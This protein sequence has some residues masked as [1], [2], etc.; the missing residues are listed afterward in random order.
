M[1]KLLLTYFYRLP[2]KYSEKLTIQ[3]I[4]LMLFA[5][6]LG[7]MVNY[8]A[9]SN[10][11]MFSNT[12]IDSISSVNEITISH[13]TINN[14]SQVPIYSHMYTLY[15]TLFITILIILFYLYKEQ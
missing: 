1:D 10:R 11:Q 6:I 8:W 12:A 9:F 5:P 3:N 14:I 7:L 13:H 2:P 4:M 15:Y